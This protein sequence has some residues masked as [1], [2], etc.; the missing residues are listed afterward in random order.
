MAWG[1]VQHINA[2]GGNT[3]SPLT[4]L[5]PATVTAGS[6]LVLK[7]AI[8]NSVT[9]TVTDNV[10]GSWTQAGSYAGPSASNKAA[11]FYFPN[12]GAG[13]ITVTVT[14]SGSAFLAGNVEEISGVVTSNP[15]DGTQTN[16]GTSATFST[17]TI[18]VSN[19]SS[20]VA[21]AFAFGSPIG[22]IEAAENTN[23][24]YSN[25]GLSSIEQAIFVDGTLSANGALGVVVNT[26]LTYAAA[27]ASFIPVAGGGGGSGGG[28]LARL[29]GG[30]SG[31]G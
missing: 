30:L 9:V 26:S 22:G 1:R 8:Y 7:L 24:R 6:L 25:A 20:Y 31:V 17:G 28:T 12:S 4:F 13:T 23:I 29:P 18:T 14:P 19:A 5:F 11:V 16:T 21:G 10:N 15:L 3:S 2:S 27:G